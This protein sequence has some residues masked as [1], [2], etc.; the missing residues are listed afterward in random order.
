MQR[1]IFAFIAGF[2]AVIFFHQPLLGL[3]HAYGVVPF[4]PFST[5]ATAPLQVPAWLSACFWGG[6][7]GVLMVAVLRWQGGRPLP[8]LKGLLFGGIALTT[9][10]L[11]VVFPLKGLGFD[12]KLLPG[13]FLIGF[14]LNAAWGVGTLIFA[15]LLLARR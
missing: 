9:V 2:L 4:A 8:W 5:V 3:L 14:I 13:R 7:W 12:A 15:H 6:V 1:W 11:L 10:A